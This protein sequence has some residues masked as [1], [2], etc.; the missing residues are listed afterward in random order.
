[1]KG[2]YAMKQRE[3]M[4]AVVGLILGLIVGITGSSAGLF[5]TAGGKDDDAKNEAR[6]TKDERVLYRVS[7]ADAE[8]YLLAELDP[9]SEEYI[10]LK[11]ELDAMKEY[12]GE[13]DFTSVFGSAVDISPID[14]VLIYAYNRIAGEELDEEVAALDEAEDDTNSLAIIVG[15]WADPYVLE[16]AELFFYLKIPKDMVESAKLPKEWEEFEV[17]GQKPLET[18]IYW[19]SLRGIPALQD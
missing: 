13:D 18:H 4:M 17:E 11:A 9:E 7:I 15:E 1:V 5:G 14:P 10:A 19:K 12:K 8:E 2:K 3:L 16:G 6:G